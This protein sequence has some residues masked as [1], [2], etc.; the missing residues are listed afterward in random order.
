MYLTIVYDYMSQQL[1]LEKLENWP[2]AA[3]CGIMQLIYQEIG[4]IDIDSFFQVT[5]DREQLSM[6]DNS[7][8]L[9][10]YINSSTPKFKDNVFHIF[11]MQ[12]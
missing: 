1:A 6:L 9:L 2:K 5:V 3:A 4:K 11:S 8:L 10:H 7:D 12:Q